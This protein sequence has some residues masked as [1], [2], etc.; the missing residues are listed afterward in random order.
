MVRVMSATIASRLRHI[1]DAILAACGPYLECDELL[2]DVERA[3]AV[4]VNLTIIITEGEDMSK[5]WVA[6]GAILATSEEVVPIFVHNPQSQKIEATV[7]TPANQLFVTL[8]QLFGTQ[9]PQAPSAT[10]S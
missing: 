7:V 8:A 6:L 5:L 1:R 3:G 4:P 2:R 9:A 10:G